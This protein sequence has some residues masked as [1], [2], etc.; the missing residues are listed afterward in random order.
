M[1]NWLKEYLKDTPIE[2]VKSEWKSIQER[3]PKGVNAFEYI[4]LSKV[5]YRYSPPPEK[6][7]E[8]NL[9]SKMTSDFSGSFFLV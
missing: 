7:P 6:L 1:L 2:T 5:V 8:I 9:S 4:E 3:F